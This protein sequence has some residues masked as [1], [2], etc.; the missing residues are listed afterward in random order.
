MK[1]DSLL[2]WLKKQEDLAWKKWTKEPGRTPDAYRLLSRY[3]TLKEVI[4]RLT[5]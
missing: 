4:K 5:K 3:Y 1:N 2:D